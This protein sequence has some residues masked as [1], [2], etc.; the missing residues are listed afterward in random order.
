MSLFILIRGIRGLQRERDCNSCKIFSIRFDYLMS[1]KT[2][3]SHLKL[4][5]NAGYLSE[6]I[7][8]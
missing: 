6:R 8:R 1:N 4:F 5:D 2:K 3:F 7:E